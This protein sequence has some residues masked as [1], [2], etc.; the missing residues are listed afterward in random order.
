MSENNYIPSFIRNHV[1][2][3]TAVGAVAGFISDVVTPL[4]PV[5]LYV[6]LVVGTL[7][8]AMVLINRYFKSQ[9]VAGLTAV[10]GVIAV[11]NGLVASGQYLTGTANAGISGSQF[12]IVADLQHALGIVQ[13]DLNELKTSVGKIEETTSQIAKNSM[14]QLQT[15]KDIATE[16]GNSSTQGVVKNPTTLRD[17]YSNAQLLE[18]TGNYI[19]SVNAYK[20][21]VLLT[22]G[23]IDPIYRLFQ[24]VANRDGTD[25]AKQELLSSRTESNRVPIDILVAT[26]ESRSKAVENLN[27]IEALA[28]NYLPLYYLRANYLIA[29]RDADRLP[30]AT[31]SA[32]L[33][34]LLAFTEGS[35][36]LDLASQFVDLNFLN[37]WTSSAVD[38]EDNLRAHIKKADAVNADAQF[39]DNQICF[40]VDTAEPISALVLFDVI[41]SKHKDISD[42]S[43]ADID[44]VWRMIDGGSRPGARECSSIKVDDMKARYQLDSDGA[45]KAWYRDVDGNLVPFTMTLP[46]PIIKGNDW[47]LED[48]G[49]TSQLINKS[50]LA[51]VRN[52]ASKALSLAFSFDSKVTGATGDIEFTL[53]FR[54]GKCSDERKNRFYHTLEM[55][56]FYVVLDIGRKTLV[57]E[58]YGSDAINQYLT[59]F[60]KGNTVNKVFMPPGALLMAFVLDALSHCE[61]VQYHVNPLG[62]ES[63]LGKLGLS[64]I[65]SSLQGITLD[66]FTEISESK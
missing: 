39:V 18:S 9:F 65:Y 16:V 62:D 28:P 46:E 57:S 13:T 24:L 43:N 45:L 38:T 61:T 42:Y 12:S 58:A 37:Q 51:I 30:F 34:D 53:S 35:R 54:P 2:A 31:A 29:R 47:L 56:F 14:E 52:D 63:A 27:S 32:A 59:Q 1:P 3:L 25:K 5:A 17:F 7:V 10:S 41:E 4:A 15:L 8:C 60:K 55:N 23:Q 22:T 6:A 19:A 44:E 11:C 64:D 66:Q 50:G 20:E 40:S 21:A 36:S 26:L 33:K 48:T 49:E